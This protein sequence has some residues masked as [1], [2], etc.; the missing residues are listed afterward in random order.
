MDTEGGVWVTSV[1]DVKS[2]QGALWCSPAAA[3]VQWSSRVWSD[4]CEEGEV[5]GR[6]GE[7]EQVE[8]ESGSGQDGR[9]QSG[10]S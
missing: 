8:G 3:V 7:I 4:M 5:G 1:A 6:V 10:W 2:V 9:S